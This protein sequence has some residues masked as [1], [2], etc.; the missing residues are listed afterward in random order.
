ML[1][2]FGINYSAFDINGNSI[3]QNKSMQSTISKGEVIAEKIDQPSWENCKKIMRSL[4]GELTE[5]EFKGKYYL[6]LKQ[7]IIENN[8]CV[9]IVIIS[10]DVT[11]KK[12][13][14]IA[15]RAKQIFS[16]NMA[17]DIRTPF[18]AIVGFAQLQAMGVLKTPEEVQNYGK[19]VSDSGTQV[20][21]ILN[22]G[23]CALDKNE[24]DVIK[25]DKIDLYK[26]AIEMQALITPSIYMERLDFELNVDK[27]I[28]EIVTDKIRLK[29]ILTNLLSNAVKFT[30]KGKGKVTLSFE[31]TDKLKITVSD[32]GIGIS[33][34][35][36]AR[37]FDKFV[38]IK[39]SYESP[40]FTGSGMG[41]YLTKKYVEELNG[42]INLISSFGE[43]STFQLEI[44]SLS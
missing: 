11:E 9:G 2:A 8:Q 15:E 26:F 33:E 20:L 37:I 10:F 36:H 38:K 22:A 3:V 30:P 40:V 43:G 41:L 12:Q 13:G 19:M 44:P 16:M 18:S 39:P 24:I 28:G 5:E 17:H 35:D 6:S 29:Q 31:K 23:L 4:K 7:P 27:N 34:E 32:T 21:E 42:K 14:E 25:K 1:D